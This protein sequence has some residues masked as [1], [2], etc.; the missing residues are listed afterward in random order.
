M[1]EQT[2]AWKWEYRGRYLNGSE[3]DW[4]TEPEALDSFIPLQL[5][6]F[7]AM[8]ELFKGTSSGARPPIPPSRKERDKADQERTLREMPV[9][10]SI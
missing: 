6:V 10:T 4:I 5:D 8:W 7:H 9:D 3:S 2:G 1:C